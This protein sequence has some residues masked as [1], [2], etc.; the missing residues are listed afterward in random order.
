MTVQQY[1]FDANAI[2]RLFR[3]C[4]EKAIDMLMEGTTISLAYY[5]LG[6]A[7]WREA[8]LLKRISIEEAEKSLILVYAMLMRMK[9]VEV[10]GEQGIEILHTASKCNLTFYDSAYLIAA[11]KTIKILVTDDNKLAKA[12]EPLGVKTLSSNTL[13]GSQEHKG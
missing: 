6:N 2:F 12:A 3:E 10:D 11:K 9:I 5:E 7:L 1:L 4:P 13:T 8:H